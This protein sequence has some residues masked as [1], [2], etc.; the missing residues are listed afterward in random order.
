[1]YKR[2]LGVFASLV[3]AFATIGANGGFN[4]SNGPDPAYSE[5]IKFGQSVDFS[6]GQ[7]GVFMPKSA[8]TGTLTIDRMRPTEVTPP[9]GVDFTD[10]LMDVQVEPASGKL[11]SFLFGLNYVY[12][13]LSEEQLLAWKNG[14]LAIYRYDSTTQK[15]VEMPTFFVNEGGGRVAAAMTS[16][17]LYGLGQTSFKVTTSAV[18]E[19]GRISSTAITAGEAVD[20]SSGRAG[21]FLPKSGYTG[22]LVISLLAADQV[23]SIKNV[24]FEE[25]AIAFQVEL[26]NGQT[27]TVLHGLNYVYFNLTKDELRTWENGNLAIYHYNAVTKNWAKLSTFFVNRADGRI[28]SV[29]PGFGLYALGTSSSQ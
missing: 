18:S 22:T 27:E 12:Y 23:R 8:Y 21:I 17:G 29:A 20:F 9:K 15:W 6:V 19:Q 1:M 14:E 4:F 3:L 2:I 7:N 10:R 26:A 16:F 5:G 24:H 11:P 28:A 25:S 13:G